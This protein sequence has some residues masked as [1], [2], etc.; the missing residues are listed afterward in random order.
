MDWNRNL[1]QTC[2]IRVEKGI[3][4]KFKGNRES[5]PRLSRLS[6]IADTRRV[7]TASEWICRAKMETRAGINANVEDLDS[8][9]G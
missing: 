5:S 6:P 7:S 2:F 9:D 4:V 8:P 3:P 1:V